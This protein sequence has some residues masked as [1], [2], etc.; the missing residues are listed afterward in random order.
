[1]WL[2]RK[3][4]FPEGLLFYQAYQEAMGGA[5]VIAEKVVMPAA[6]EAEVRKPARER[7]ARR[8]S[9][10][11]PALLEESAGGIFGFKKR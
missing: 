8:R 5:P 2:L 3:S 11:T 7:P 1:K 9:A 4:Y 6:V 10:R